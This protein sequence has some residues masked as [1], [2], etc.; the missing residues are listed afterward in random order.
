MPVNK[1][2]EDG[3]ACCSRQ[4]LSMKLAEEEHDEQYCNLGF[5][6]RFDIGLEMPVTEGQEEEHTFC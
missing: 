3:H 1:A 5:T 2:Q 6:A 4:G